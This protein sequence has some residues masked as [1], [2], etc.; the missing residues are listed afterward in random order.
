MKMKIAFI[1][2]FPLFLLWWGLHTHS[3]ARFGGMDVENSTKQKLTSDTYLKNWAALKGPLPEALRPLGPGLIVATHILVVKPLLYLVSRPEFIKKEF[4]FAWPLTWICALLYLFVFGHMVMRFP[5]PA[6]IV[7]AV[8]FGMTP[9]LLQ[10]R[11][12]ALF[13]PFILLFWSLCFYFIPK[14]LS[15]PSIGLKNLTL[16]GLLSGWMASWTMEYLGL[17]LAGLWLFLVLTEPLHG[18]KKTFRWLLLGT[19]V[20]SFIALF[21]SLSVATSHAGSS[22]NELTQGFAAH[23]AELRKINK[24]YIVGIYLWLM[25]RYALFS[26]V[27]VF[28]GGL[29][30]GYKPSLEARK[31]IGLVTL[32]GLACLFSFVLTLLVQRHFFQIDKVWYHIFFPFSYLMVWTSTG[33]ALLISSRIN[34]TVGWQGVT[35]KFHA[36]FQKMFT[37]V[38]KI[39]ETWFELKPY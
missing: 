16:I 34:E 37:L 9:F 15:G 27:A 5:L 32:T 38:K 1:V 23:S 12:I 19:S 18:V 20:G 28:A 29:I 13:D 21:I 31:K 30:T 26:C 2:A 4:S 25:S 39:Y 24:F 14:L 8:T 17:S 7:A 6:G 36:P 33:L 10:Y 22:L 11:Q 35:A 3:P